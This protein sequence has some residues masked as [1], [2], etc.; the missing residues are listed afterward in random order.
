MKNFNLIVST[1]RFREEEAQAEILDLLEQFGD[2]ESEC[3]ITEIKGI[4]LANST[5]DPIE[6]VARLKALISSDPW[7][8]R[9]IL[10]VLPIE[11]VVATDLGCIRLAAKE[12]ASRIGNVDRFRITVEKRHSPLSSTDI[13]SSIAGEIQSKVDLDNPDWVVLVQVLGA[14]TGISVIRPQQTFSSIKEKRQ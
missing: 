1:Y 9:Y 5:I 8:I 6:A 11:A 14:K 7:Q 4:L 10:R 12:L 13:I 2:P 3:E